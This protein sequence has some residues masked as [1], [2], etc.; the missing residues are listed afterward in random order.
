MK[1]HKISKIMIVSW[2]LLGS[3]MAMSYSD[4]D[5]LSSDEIFKQGLIKQDELN[6]IQDHLHGIREDLKENLNPTQV[7]SGLIAI[8]ARVAKLDQ[9]TLA[10]KIPD[11]RGEDL[12]ELTGSFMRQFIIQ[13]QDPSNTMAQ[14]EAEAKA[15]NQD[16]NQ[17]SEEFKKDNDTAQEK[18][19]EQMPPVSPFG[20]VE[21]KSLT[22]TSSSLEAPIFS[23]DEAGVSA[24]AGTSA[25]SS[26]YSKKD[27]SSSLG[28][29]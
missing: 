3:S 5:H 29:K 10:H 1:T 20:S 16:Q 26:F 13:N 12:L 28:K 2:L 11:T 7:R 27:H 8:Y 21:N 22:T 6:E 15:L 17:H 25:G 14:F 9:E 18:L 24:G 19:I 4:S 23:T